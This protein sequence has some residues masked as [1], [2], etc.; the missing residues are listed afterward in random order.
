MKNGNRLIKIGAIGGAITALCCFTPVLV[1]L[2]ALLGISVLVGY[3]DYVLLPMLAMFLILLVIGF[4]QRWR[5]KS[6]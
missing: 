3:L 2:F 5:A 1:W 6:T 4:V